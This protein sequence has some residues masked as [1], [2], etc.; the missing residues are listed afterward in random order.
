MPHRILKTAARG[1]LDAY[2]ALLATRGFV[3]DAAQC[4]AAERLQRLYQE[5][6][7]FKVA[8]RGT[9]RR[10]FSPPSPPRGLYF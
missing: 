8:R 9:L 1:M 6:L 5:L 3:A 10:I 7:S 4:T 2:E